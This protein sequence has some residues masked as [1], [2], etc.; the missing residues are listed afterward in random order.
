MA[1][2]AHYMN[3]VRI[4]KDNPLITTSKLP[5]FITYLVTRSWRKMHRRIHHWSSQGFIYYLGQVDEATL[6]DAVQPVSPLRNDSSFSV[7]LMGMDRKNVIRKFVTTTS[8]GMPLAITS[9]LTSCRDMEMMPRR[10]GLEKEDEVSGLYNKTT[11]FEFHQLLVSILLSFGKAL[12]GYADAHGKK[13]FEDLVDRA[14]EVYECG[15]LLWFIGY[16]RILRSHLNVL[17]EEGWLHLPANSKEDLDKFSDFTK[18]KKTKD[19]VIVQPIDEV[20]GDADG[21]GSSDES[22]VDDCGDEGGEDEDERAAKDQ[23]IVQPTDEVDRGAD[24]ARNSGEDGV[25]DCG[26]EGSEDEDECT[27]QDQ[28]IVQPTDEVDD[29]ADEAGNNGE[30]G[31]DD[32]GN[33]GSKDEDERAAKDQVIVQPTDEVDGGANE[34]EEFENIA[35]TVVSSGLSKS[36]LDWIRLQVDRFQAARKITSFMKRTRTPPIALTLLAVRVPTP[37]PAGEVMEPWHE[38]IKNLCVKSKNVKPE[39]TIR[40]LQ[41]KIDKGKRAI[42]ASCDDEKKKTSIF[43]KFDAKTYQYNAAVHCE[44]ALASME[45]YPSAVVCDDALKAHIQVW[46]HFRY[47]R[48]VYKS[49]ALHRISTT[50]Q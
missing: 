39:E 49:D 24:E 13:R 17:R 34:D 18:F 47:H 37:K 23:V 35:D 30:D 20:N 15:T 40:I 27:A 2:V 43:H 9:L 29:G 1:T 31:V 38:T 5:Q 10:E 19:Q 32:C 21:A 16:S 45:K 50:A 41:E 14:E 26:N 46:F 33:G 6:R 12:D 7:R 22:G 3:H 44:A 25:D 42:N 8:T 28:V 11:C 48:N 36:F 4:Y